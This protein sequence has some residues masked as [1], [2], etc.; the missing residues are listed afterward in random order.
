MRRRSAQD[1]VGIVYEGFR[2]RWHMTWSVTGTQGTRWPVGGGVPRRARGGMNRK[3]FL[4]KG[5]LGPG[6]ARAQ[7]VYLELC[8]QVGGVGRWRRSCNRCPLSLS[9]GLD[10]QD[11]R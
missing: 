7:G 3:A 5:P 2:K 6:R 11:R 4:T 9:L 10:K 1:N 8:E